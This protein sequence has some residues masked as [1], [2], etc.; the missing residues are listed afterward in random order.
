MRRTQKLF[1]CLVIIVC[2]SMLNVSAGT[3]LY[4]EGDDD[5]LLTFLRETFPEAVVYEEPTTPEEW[6]VIY[7]PD[8]D[9]IGY[10]VITSPYADDIVGYGGPVPLLVCIDTR[11]RIQSVTL[12]THFETIGLME[13]LKEGGFMDIWNGRTWEDALDQNVDA[14]SGATMSS[15]A[16]IDTLKKRLRMMKSP[17]K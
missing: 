14:V 10:A 17:K 6:I 9:V 13:L 16:I 15:Q 1:G 7:N 11:E 8:Q 4:R 3:M 5:V 2:F 12:L